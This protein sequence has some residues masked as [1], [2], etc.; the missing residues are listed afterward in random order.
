VRYRNERRRKRI[1]LGMFMLDYGEIEDM[2]LE[3][4][5]FFGGGK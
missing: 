1:E 4:L 5:R 2:G 3:N